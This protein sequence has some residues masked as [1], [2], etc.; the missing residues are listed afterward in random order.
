M[1]YP[2]PPPT[3]AISSVK[4]GILPFVLW[5]NFKGEC[6]QTELSDVP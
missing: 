1:Q 2:P 4:K 3:T 5:M 6:R